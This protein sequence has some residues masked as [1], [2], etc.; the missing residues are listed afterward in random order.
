ME[1]LA[2]GHRGETLDFDAAKKAAGAAHKDLA[3]VRIE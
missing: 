1:L 2:A 3:I